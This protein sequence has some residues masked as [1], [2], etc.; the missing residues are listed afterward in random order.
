MKADLQGE[1]KLVFEEKGEEGS[2]QERSRILATQNLGIQNTIYIL[3]LVRTA[4]YLAKK[5]L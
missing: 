1:V 4:Q 5:A 2:E 3:T